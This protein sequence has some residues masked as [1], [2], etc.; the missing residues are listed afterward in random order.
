MSTAWTIRIYYND[1]WCGGFSPKKYQLFPDCK[2]TSYANLKSADQVKYLGALLHASLQDDNDTQK[3]LSHSIAQQTSSEAP[4]NTA[5]QQLKKN[6]VSCLLHCNVCLLFDV[7][8]NASSWFNSTSS[9]A[10]KKQL[11]ITTRAGLILSTHY[12]FSLSEHERTFNSNTDKSRVI[13]LTTWSEVCELRCFPGQT[14]ASEKHLW[15]FWLNHCCM[16]N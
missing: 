6:N 13:L 11:T 14:R 3:Q 4:L 9:N 8:C 7:T 16:Q 1:K 12:A 2:F 5:L 15:R 10:R